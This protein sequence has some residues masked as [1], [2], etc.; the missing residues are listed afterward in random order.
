MRG[1]LTVAEATA[2]HS[3]AVEACS[4]DLSHVATTATKTR[5]EAGWVGAEKAKAPWVRRGLKDAALDCNLR[6]RNGPSRGLQPDALGRAGTGGI[7]LAYRWTV[8][9][10]KPRPWRAQ[11]WMARSSALSITR[12][13]YWRMPWASL[14]ISSKNSRSKDTV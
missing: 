9:S 10:L 5:A 14:P 7:L 3:R 4:W 6:V 12:V 2:R 13:S 1:W 8:K 11:A